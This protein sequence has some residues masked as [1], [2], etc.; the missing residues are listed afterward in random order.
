MKAVGEQ[1][2]NV[3]SGLKELYKK[4]VSC[5]LRSFCGEKINLCSALLLPAVGSRS[6][7]WRQKNVKAQAKPHSIIY[8]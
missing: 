7:R 6:R 1:R 4:Q 8:G 2:G 3:S 5:V